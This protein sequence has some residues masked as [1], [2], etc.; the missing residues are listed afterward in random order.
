MKTNFMNS[1]KNGKKSN[2]DY[3][4]AI[5]GV[6]PYYDMKLVTVATDTLVIT[7]QIFVQNFNKMSLPLY[8]IESVKVPIEGQN[9]Q[10]Y[11]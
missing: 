10:A 1:F 7:F 8:E 11:S 4:L 5:N 2:P 6:P 3:T 9:Y